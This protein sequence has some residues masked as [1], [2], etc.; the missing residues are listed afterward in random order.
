MRRIVV[1]RRGDPLR[2]D[3]PTVALATLALAAA[4][5]INQPNPLNQALLTAVMPGFLER[6]GDRVSDEH[7]EVCER[8]LEV[9]RELTDAKEQ[10]RR[11]I[12]ELDIKQRL[13]G[14]RYPID[15]EFLSALTDMPPASGCALGFDR[16]V[17]LAAGATHIEQVLWTPPA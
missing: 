4:D 2:A 9:P 17:M 10:R 16:L 6:Y 8:A 1:R 5:W 7:R 11:F 12:A 15:E 3:R 14:E 13:Y